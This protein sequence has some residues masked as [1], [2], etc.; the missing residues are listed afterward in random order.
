[1]NGIKEGNVMKKI[2]ITAL[3]VLTLVMP[4]MAKTKNNSGKKISIV[5]TM[6]PQYDV[7]RSIAGE[8]ADITMLLKPGAES[9]SYEPTPQDM[10]KIQKTDLFLYT[11]G[12]NDEWVET[13]LESFGSKSPKSLKF[14]DLVDAVEEEIME[15]MTEE[16][17]EADSEH[18]HGDEDEIE[19]DE[20]VWTSPLNMIKIAN[21]VCEELC[22]IDPKN[23][24]YYR[25]NAKSFVGQLQNL[26]NEFENVVINAKRSLFVFG[27]RFPLR[28]FADTY[29]LSYYA[30]FPGCATDVEVSAA[31]LKFLINKVR[32]ENIPVVFTI[33]FSNGKIADTICESTG[34]KKLEFH[35]CHNISANDLKKGETYISLM[36]R[37]IAALKTAL[38]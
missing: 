18:H 36:T 32:Q 37:N 38:N 9:H 24:D 28:Y 26:H 8:K 4:L 5:A 19:Y 3:A 7:A 27:D 21:A 29:G 31:T 25:N 1:M 2:I 11:G 30:A 14:L 6:F 15:G 20:H 12:E 13:I 23:T 33:E 17:E 22:D 34:A 10:K 16:E 35:S